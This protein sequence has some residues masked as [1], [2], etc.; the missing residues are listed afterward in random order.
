MECDGFLCKDIEDIGT[1]KEC[2]ELNSTLVDSCVIMSCG[3]YSSKEEF[4]G[5]RTVLRGC[6]NDIGD[7]GLMCKHLMY[8]K[9]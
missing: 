7:E 8:H 3:N 5:N 4:Q 9:I 6:S 1:S 2:P